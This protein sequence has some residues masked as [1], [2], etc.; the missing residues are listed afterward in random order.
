MKINNYLTFVDLFAGIGGFHLGLKKA[1]MKCVLACEIDEYAR[2]TYEF[3]HKIHSPEI[4]N[5]DNFVKDIRTIDPKLIIDFDILCA[6]F[7]CQPFS[8]AGQKK[9]F[10]DNDDD[11]GNMFFEIMRIVKEKSCFSASLQ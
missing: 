3:N 6:G 4:F 9:G 8:Q 1:G 2:K 11:R 10:N 7:P 5:K